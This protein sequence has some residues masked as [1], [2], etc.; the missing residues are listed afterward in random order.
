MVKTE[1]SNQIS[2]QF[3]L[4]VNQ[5]F[6]NLSAISQ[7]DSDKLTVGIQQEGW[8]PVQQLRDIFAVLENN[9]RDLPELMFQ[10]GAAFIQMW[11]DNG[12]KELNLGSLGHMKILKDSGGISLV[13]RDLDPDLIFT[14]VHYLDDKNG[15]FYAEEQG[16][17]PFHFLLGLHH[18]MY[19]MWGD[20]NWINV[21]AFEL[22]TIQIS[23]RRLLKIDFQLK[24]RTR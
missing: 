4:G 20:L 23:K 10:A 22:E 16:F 11:Y 17:F 24:Q 7:T 13:T 19:F 9:N 6:Y 18:N 3:I 5:A 1:Y 12:G 21:E 14:K 15:V 2:G 8:Y